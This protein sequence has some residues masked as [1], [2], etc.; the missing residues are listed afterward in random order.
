VRLPP[1]DRHGPENWETSGYKI[2][3][4]TGEVWGERFD[5]PESLVSTSEYCATLGHKINHSFIYNCTEWFFHHP[6]HG[7][8]P[9]TRTTR[10]VLEGEELFL[11]YG[12][13]PRNCPT[14]YRLELD[15]FLE[16]HPELT[17]EEAANPER[18]EKLER[19][20]Y[21]ELSGRRNDEDNVL[22]STG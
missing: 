9:C 14:W 11:H 1:E 8:I 13:D 15:L 17:E 12:Y 22:M 2:F 7:L 20:F 6:R 18:M 4:N 19:P 10:E 21:S 16:T 5:I 3:A